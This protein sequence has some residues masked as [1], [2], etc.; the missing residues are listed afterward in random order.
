LYTCF[1]ASVHFIFNIQLITARKKN[2]ER[3]SM[4]LLAFVWLELQFDDGV[5]I[6]ITD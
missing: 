2:R 6:L 3:G 1:V 4:T 5:G